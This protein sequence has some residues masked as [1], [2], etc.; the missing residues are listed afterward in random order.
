MT[1]RNPISARSLPALEALCLDGWEAR[2]A[3]LSHRMLGSLNAVLADFTTV[4]VPARR[5]G[6][7]PAAGD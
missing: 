2:G 7:G 5:H 1:E 4:A 3:R 6:A